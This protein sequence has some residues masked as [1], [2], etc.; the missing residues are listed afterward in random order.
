MTRAVH[1]F[2]QIAFCC[3]GAAMLLA[4][5]ARAV[6]PDRITVYY[7]V[8]Y[9]GL[10]MAE[11]H[12]TLRHD[13]RTYLIESEL[14]GKGIFAIA[15]R[16]AVKRSSRG[17][18]T[19]VGLRPL[20]FRDQR[21]DRTPEYARFDWPARLV[22]H[23]REGSKQSSAIGNGTQD[24]VSFLWNFSFVPPRGEVSTQ[25]E[26]GRGTTQFRFAIAGK[27]TIKTD[28]GNIECL[29]LVKV[30]DA[31]DSRDTDVWLALDRSLI[32]IRLLVVEKNG[33]RVDQVATRI[34]S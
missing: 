18:I 12:E 14:R 23:E 8:S 20:E 13:A 26:D 7:D 29:H 4:A 3:V 17:E 16:G 22:T 15:Q 25:V 28:A 1:C 21:G 33:T 30:K 24:R 10:V 6:P 9:N 19:P 2:Q 11:G 5:P 31:G 27:E 32:P 34:E